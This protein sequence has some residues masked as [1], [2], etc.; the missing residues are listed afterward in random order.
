MSDSYTLTAKKQVL[1]RLCQQYFDKNGSQYYNNMMETLKKCTKNNTFDQESTKMIIKEIF[2]ILNE[3]SSAMIKRFLEV[4]DHI[5]LHMY[6]KLPVEQ[7]LKQS[8]FFQQC[9]E[10]VD[11]KRVQNVKFQLKKTE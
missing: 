6:N 10:Y 3:L 9:V 8:G 5:L 4:L 2:P 11:Q 1:E 7:M